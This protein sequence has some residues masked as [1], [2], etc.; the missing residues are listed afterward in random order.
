ME[1]AGVG[2]NGAEENTALVLS[3]VQG[4]SKREAERI[5]EGVIERAGV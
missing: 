1:S 2:A 3:L 5:A 4:A